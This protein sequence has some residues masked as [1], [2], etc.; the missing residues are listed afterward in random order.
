LRPAGQP[1]LAFTQRAE[2][3]G[4]IVI[5]DA[6]ARTRGA[7]FDWGLGPVGAVT[8]SLDGFRCATASRTKAVVWDVDS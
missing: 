1:L 7:R 8:F 2:D 3:V 5:W 6:Q 4:E